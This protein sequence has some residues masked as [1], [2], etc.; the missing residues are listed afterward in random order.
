VIYTAFRKDDIYIAVNKCLQP[1]KKDLGEIDA[2]VK[3]ISTQLSSIE[4]RVK[5]LKEQLTS[6]EEAVKEKPKVEK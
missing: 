4:D 2:R 1:V 6:I 3:D 5:K